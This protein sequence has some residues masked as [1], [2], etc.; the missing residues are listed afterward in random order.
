L[1]AQIESKC[2]AEVGVYGARVRKTISI[3]ILGVGNTSRLTTGAVQADNT[4]DV[5]SA[6]LSAGVEAIVARLIGGAARHLWEGD[7]DGGEAEGGDDGELH[8]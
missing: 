2:S 5:G 6:A 8:D 4:K 7:G 3:G 1:A